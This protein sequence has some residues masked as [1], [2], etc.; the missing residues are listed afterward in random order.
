MIKFLIEV[1]SKIPLKELQRNGLISW[2]VLRDRD[3]YLQWDAFVQ[4][5]DPKLVAYAKTAKAFNISKQ[6]VRRIVS[7]MK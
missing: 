6:S 5:K 7:K 4:M 1:D 3:V 2:V